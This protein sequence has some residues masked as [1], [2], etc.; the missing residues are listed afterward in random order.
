[1]VWC[2]MEENVKAYLYQMV[3]DN[4]YMKMLGIELLEVDEGYANGRIYIEDKL[5]NPNKTVHGGCLYSLADIIAGTLSYIYDEDKKAT[6][7]F[8]SKNSHVPSGLRKW[9]LLLPFLICGRDAPAWR[10]GRD[11]TSCRVPSGGGCGHCAPC[12]RPPCGWHTSTA[13]CAVPSSPHASRE[14]P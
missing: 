8:L 5:L 2:G 7:N 10:D 4:E 13:A 9:L 3:Q 14:S 6:E 11:S 1:M 12:A